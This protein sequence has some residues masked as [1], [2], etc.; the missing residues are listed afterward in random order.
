MSSEMIARVIVAMCFGIAL[1]LFITPVYIFIRKIMYGPFTNKKLL[2]KAIDAGHIV[3]AKL[4]KSYGS[5]NKGTEQLIYEYEWEGKTYKYRCI[6]HSYTGNPESFELYFINNPR[7]AA[8]CDE[9]YVT[10]RSPW[11][12]S[13]LIITVIISI[14]AFFMLSYMT[15]EKLTDSIENS[16]K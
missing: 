10:A 13:Y 11:I 7:K 16:I 3:Q 5:L 4:V 12:V 9:L 6:S 8:N 14:I 1:S 15:P 2:K